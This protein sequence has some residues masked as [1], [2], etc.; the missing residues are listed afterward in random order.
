MEEAKCRKNKYCRFEQIGDYSD[1]FKEICVYC[2]RTVIWNKDQF[3]RIDNRKFLRFHLRDF[4]QPYGL[5]GK[6]F[7][8][9]YGEEAFRKAMNRPS[10]KN[11]SLDEAAEDAKVMLRDLR[12]EKVI[13]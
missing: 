9:V 1:A 11:Y 3:G 7:A 13:V 5:T 2:S 8:Q 10:K 4:C 6:V 12:K